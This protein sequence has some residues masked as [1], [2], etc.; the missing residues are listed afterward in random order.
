MICMIQ[1]SIMKK[2]DAFSLADRDTLLEKIEGNKYIYL[3]I[4]VFNTILNYAYMYLSLSLSPTSH[5]PPLVVFRILVH[6]HT[7]NMIQRS[8]FWYTWPLLN[9]RNIPM[10]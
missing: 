1:A 6:A 9:L 5:L 10:K 2:S 4:Y 3:C 8:R 7:V